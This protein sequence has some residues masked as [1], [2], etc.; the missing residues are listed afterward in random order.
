[1]RG[2]LSIYAMLGL[3]LIISISPCLC[4]EQTSP[5]EESK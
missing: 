2:T 4:A 5:K 3:D 1:M